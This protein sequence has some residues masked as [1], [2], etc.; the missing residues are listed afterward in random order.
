MSMSL[1]G[2]TP[3]TAIIIPTWNTKRWL[4]GCLNGLRAQTHRDFEIVV[5][6][7]GSTDGSVEFLRQNYPEVRLITFAQNRGFA[8]AVNAGIRATAG[9]YVALLNVDTVPHPDWLAALV[10]VVK[11]SPPT[12]GSLASKMLLMDNPQILDDAGN[13]FSWY[14]SAQKRGKGQPADTFTQMDE[15]LSACGGAGLFRRAFLDD[16]G[17]LDEQFVSYLEDVDLGLR[18][19]LLGYTC[20]FV[21][22][23]Q[24]LHK[25]HGAGLPRANYVFY[26]TRN[27][28]A[29]L[30]K[31]IPWRLLV[32]HAGTLLFGQLY[33]FLAYKKPLVS[34]AAY[35]AFL[36]VLPRLCRQRRQ[37]LR[38]QIISLDALNRRLSS[39]LG[40]PP[41]RAMLAA[42]FWQS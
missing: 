28:L 11:S 30:L 23:S 12:V 2:N 26:S 7:N 38:R 8:P 16:A 40:E 42:K 5:V 25:W 35:G 32:K 37:I 1:N 3:E 18:G 19:Q 36:L 14:G 33:F 15:V 31:N 6:D 27:R 22:Q 9:P 39:T 20:L 4:P 21:P 29:V 41:L 24:V 10:Q 17:G 34:L 13:L